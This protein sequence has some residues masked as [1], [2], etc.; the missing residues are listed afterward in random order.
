[1]GK[2]SYENHNLESTFDTLDMSLAA[3]LETRRFAA[4]TSGLIYSEDIRMVGKQTEWPT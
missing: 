1:M 3:G 2:D 4:Q